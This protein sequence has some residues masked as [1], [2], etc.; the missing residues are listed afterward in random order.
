VSEET[1][2]RWLTTFG[3]PLLLALIVVLPRLCAATFVVTPARDMVRYVEGAEALRTLPLAEALRSMDSHPLY[4]AA[5]LGA[6]ELLTQSLG[7]SGPTAWV[8]AGQAVGVACYVLFIL[9]SYAVGRRF[10]DR[11][12]A[13]WG[14]AIVSLTPRQVS[15]TVDVL[16]DSLHAWMWMTSVYFMT[17]VER[18]NPAP[19]FAL[20]GLFAGVAYWTRSEAL[21][22]PAM[23]CF[24]GIVIQLVPTWRLPWKT[25]AAC[26][27]AFGVCWGIP[28]GA[29]MGAVG[30]LSPRNSAAAL[31]GQLTT[32][33]PIVAPTPE[34]AKVGDTVVPPPDQAPTLYVPPT[35]PNAPNEP[36]VDLTPRPYEG[37]EGYELRP[38]GKAFVAYL[39]EIAQETRVWML[40][41]AVWGLA[42]SAPLFRR[43]ASVFFVMAWLGYSAMLVL[44][45]MKCG[46][47]AGRYLMPLMPTLGMSAV[48]GIGATLRACGDASHWSARFWRASK[49]L[50]DPARNRRL[51]LGTVVVVALATCAPAWF[52]SNH[53]HRQSY[54]DAAAWLKEHTRPGEAVFD[55]LDLV[56]FY[57]DRPNW[58]PIDPDQPIPVRYAVV[59]VERVYRSDLMQHLIIK[60]FNKT[61]TVAA[62]FKQAKSQREGV[63]YILEWPQASARATEGGLR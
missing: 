4:P 63:V 48:V 2:R 26:A 15:Y 49:L 36:P 28:V 46:Y 3:P 51:A 32:A 24:G 56:A 40:P 54:V 12:T 17:S 45:Q 59:D 16:T 14:C 9:T 58:R 50:R 53:R 1:P 47:I 35:A 27:A 13:F 10:F 39:Y 41:F 55:P 23:A 52:R 57:A 43:P 6:R 25:A 19:R 44:L 37:H 38:F 21:L 31:T 60:R 42:L 18:P 7:M 20:A 5:L 30:K 22:L 33:E 8:V 29:Y 62:R 34:L 61:A 11:R